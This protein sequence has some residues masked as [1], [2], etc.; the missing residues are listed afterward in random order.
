MVSLQVHA[1][2]E[3]GEMAADMYHEGNR[4]PRAPRAEDVSHRVTWVS[5]ALTFGLKVEKCQPPELPAI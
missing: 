2:I 5:L 3:W 1:M 4:G